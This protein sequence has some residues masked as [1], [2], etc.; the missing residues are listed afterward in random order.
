MPLLLPNLDDRTWADLVAEANALIPV[1]GSEWTDQNCSDPGITLV[2]LCAWIVEM[3][4]YQLNQVSDQERLKFLSLVG[5]KPKPPAAAHTVLS[6][7]LKSGVAPLS[8]P[9]TLEFSGTDPFGTVTSYRTLHPITLAQG[10]LA[11]IQF[12]DSFGYHDLTPQWL[13]GSAL[14][15]FGVEPQPGIE[16]YLAL[17]AALPVGQPIQLFFN[18]ADGKSGFEERRRLLRN[19]QES[20]TRCNRP[21]ANPCEKKS[22]EGAAGSLATAI[23]DQA[24]RALRSAHGMAISGRRGRAIAVDFA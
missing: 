12:Q 9:A 13:R 1:Y 6:L 20:E 24:A 3:D 2:E 19:A 8:L 21:P 11:A 22:T 18:F 5:V 4:I 16:F 7:L 10:S 14:S 15:P 17:T 23:P